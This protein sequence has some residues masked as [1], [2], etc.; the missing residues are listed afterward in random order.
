MKIGIIGSGNM[1]RTLGM[2]WEEK[3]HDVFFG[4]RNTSSIEHIQSLSKKTIISGSLKEAVEYGDILFYSLRDTLP[5]TI[6]P[7][8]VFKNKIL[9]DPNN[10][11]IPQDFNYPPITKSFA[12]LYQ[13]NILEAHVVKAF[14][15][16][17]Q[18]I[19][20]LPTDEIK[21]YNI[22]SPF[23]TN[24]E[25]AKQAV[26]SLIEDIGLVALDCGTIGQ[27]AKLLE[28]FADLARLLIINKQMGGTLGFSYSVLPMAEQNTYGT[29]QP[30]KYK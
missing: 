14:N 8:E 26:T 10:G 7:K 19:Y 16:M 6:C 13:S 12:E 15:T 17:A 27:S 22:I 11:E 30:T 2:L 4:A 18:E 29:R 21:R 23:S 5:T 25:E 24:S 1:G 3:G 28:S 20:Y 9:I